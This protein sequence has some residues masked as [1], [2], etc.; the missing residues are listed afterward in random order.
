MNGK[1][2]FL[3][4]GFMLVAALSFFVGDFWSHAVCALGKA[5]A[6]GVLVLLV[7][8]KFLAGIT[9]IHFLL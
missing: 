3:I 6:A 9:G 8:S 2:K 4:I 5:V 1:K 7:F